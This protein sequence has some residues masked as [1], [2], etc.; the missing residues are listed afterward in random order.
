MVTNSNKSINYGR[1]GSYV[2]QIGGYQAFAPKPLPPDPP[3]QLNCL[4]I[5]IKDQSLLLMVL[6]R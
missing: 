2:S 1:A 5:Y 6:L 3:V 4:N